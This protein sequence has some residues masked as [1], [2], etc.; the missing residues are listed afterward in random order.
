[1]KILGT[2]KALPKHYYS[3]DELLAA[4]REELADKYFN[5][6]RV[7]KLHKNVLVGGRHLAIPLEQLRE[8]ET[9]GQA[10]N[11]FIEQAQTLGET[12]IVEA[13]KQ[14]GTAP[15]D[16][17]AILFTTVTGLATPS[18]DARLMN[19][20]S[21]QSDTV[22]MPFF[23]LGCVGGAAGLSR[24]HDWLLGHPDKLAVLLTV[25][26]CSLTLQRTDLSIPNLIS[27]GLF[28]DGAAAVVCAGAE[29]PLAKEST[30]PE[31]VATKS[32]FFPDTESAMGWN[33]SEKGFGIVL[34][35]EVPGLVRAKLR[36]VTESF[37][38]EHDLQL[39]DL[40]VWICHPG[41]PKVLTAV[42]DALGISREDLAISW[43]NLEAMGNLSSASVLIN[44]GETIEKVS[45]PGQM[46]LL[47]AMGPGFCAELVLLKF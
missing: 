1:M 3:Q 19:R 39:N 24:C 2:G 23:G 46:G 35:A 40:S 38:S 37:L 36:D 27:T 32:I 28:G 7:E 9:F 47:L 25:E 13:S 33:I 21:L 16:L 34:S 31:V 44:L 43:D 8:I 15:A 26:L 42:Q 20:L 30:G 4:L 12:A 18:I 45:E 22:R 17:N 6:P 10:N 5:F 29:H 41:G 14:A 11:H